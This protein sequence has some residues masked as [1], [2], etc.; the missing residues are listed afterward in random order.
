MVDE[1]LQATDDAEAK[2]ADAQAV[3]CFLKEN[4][5]DL[6]AKLDDASVK[7]KEKLT[8]KH[9]A[10][11]GMLR[12]SCESPSI[13]RPIGRLFARSRSRSCDAWGLRGLSFVA[14]QQ[15]RATTASAWRKIMG[16]RI[17]EQVNKNL[18]EKIKALK[19]G[20]KKSSFPSS[21]NH[22]RKC[23]KVVRTR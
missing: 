18:V 2:V 16:P 14:L 5:E 4:L 17:G 19:K 7:V 21:Q 13:S 1:C 12:R 10:F 8:A 15:T 11:L 6:A 3:V 23:S 22:G 20:K 9:A